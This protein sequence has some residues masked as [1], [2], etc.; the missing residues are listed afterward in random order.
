MQ[1][2]ILYEDVDEFQNYVHISEDMGIPIRTSE[3]ELESASTMFDLQL[4]ILHK[5]SDSAKEELKISFIYASDIYNK[6]MI[7][8]MTNRFMLLLDTLFLH[9]GLQLAIAQCSLVLS[10]EHKLMDQ[11]NDTKADFGHRTTIHEAIVAT[12]QD[13][14]KVHQPAVVLDDKY[15][16]YGQLLEKAQRLAAHLQARYQVKQGDTIGQCVERSIDMIVGMFAIMLS[17]RCSLLSAESRGSSRTILLTLIQDTHSN[18][19]SH[20]S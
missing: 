18:D 6:T 7:K 1:T 13:P 2:V 14:D 20:P 17:R 4:Q 12:C 9:D 8:K 19:C 16:T 3:L 15:I 11:L 10:Y 5:R